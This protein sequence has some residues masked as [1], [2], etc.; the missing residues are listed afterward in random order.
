MSKTRHKARVQL[1]KAGENE[2]RCFITGTPRPKEELIRFTIGPD[3]MLYPDVAG[4][5]GGRGVWLIPSRPVLEEAMARQAF[6]RALQAKVV[7]PAALPEQV[8]MLLK[9]RCLDLIGL[10]KKAGYLII[11]ADKIKDAAKKETLPILVQA[12]DGS[13]T[14]EKHLKNGLRDVFIINDFTKDEIDQALGRDFCVHLALKKCK[15]ADNLK[16]EVG[17]LRAYLGKEGKQND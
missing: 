6:S 10:A 15:I 5:L 7:L 16:I 13:Q 17:R 14:E 3:N 2:R 9:K 8:E 4:K 1:L 11:G 12:S